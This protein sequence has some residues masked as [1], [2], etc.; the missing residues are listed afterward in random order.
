M[1]LTLIKK[2][3]DKDRYKV[4]IPKSIACLSTSNKMVK[5]I[6]EKDNHHIRST[7]KDNEK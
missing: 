5:N 4:N 7:T 3:G 1:P 6:I 2:F